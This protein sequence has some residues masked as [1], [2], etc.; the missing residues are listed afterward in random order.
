MSAR[1]S[2]GPAGPGS[3]GAGGIA[4]GGVGGGFGGGAVGGGGGWG[5]GGG[6]N[7]GYGNRT[8]LTTGATMPGTSAFGRPGGPAMGYGMSPAAARQNAVQGLIA[9]LGQGQMP[10]VMPGTPPVAGVPAPVVAPPAPVVAPPPMPSAFYGPWLDQLSGFVNAVKQRYPGQP[11]VSAPMAPV[12]PGTDMHIGSQLTNGGGY[13]RMGL[14]APGFS[15]P[16]WGAT[17]SAPGGGRSPSG[18]GGGW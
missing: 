5:N 13:G 3:G 18:G 11:P 6:M 12:T 16:S 9:R 10:G 7:G 8:G 14:N 1:D 15:G 2:A 17:E 4:N